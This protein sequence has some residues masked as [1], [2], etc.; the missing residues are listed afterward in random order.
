MSSNQRTQLVSSLRDVE[1]RRAFVEEEISTGLAFQIRAMR[2][3]RGWSQ[4]ELGNRVPD[5]TPIAQ[6]QVCKFENPD[7]GRYSLSTL[8]RLAAAFDVGLVVRFVPFS[9][10][11][12]WTLRL[13]P[14]D[15]AV[16]SFEHDSN[17]TAGLSSPEA[18]QQLVYQDSTGPVKT[19]G[20]EQAGRRLQVRTGQVIRFPIRQGGATDPMRLKTDATT[21]RVAYGR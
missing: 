17:L 9:Q 21:T 5:G 14:A 12:D 16:P 18:E 11:V 6:E 2:Q 10:L 1:Y 8:K 7:Y 19:T 13:S 15:L 4:R 3:A 20:A